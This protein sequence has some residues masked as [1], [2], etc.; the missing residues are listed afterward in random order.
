MAAKSTNAILRALTAAVVLLAGGLAAYRSQAAAIVGQQTTAEIQRP[1]SVPRSLDQMKAEYRRP[2]TIPFPPTNPHTLEKAVLGKKLYFDTRLS[3]GNLLS[4][5]TCHNPAFGWGDAQPKAI[6]HGMNVL[7]RRSPSIVNAAWSQALMWDGREATLETQALGPIAAA[8][9]MNMPLAVL[10]ERLAGIGE[11]KPLFTAAFGTNAVTAQNVAKALATFERTVVSAS[12]P[13]DSWIA[14]DEKA[15]SE[16]A[17]RGFAL[18][19]TKAGCAQCHSGWNFTD[20]SF[21]DIG[22]ESPD[23]GRGKLVPDT[24]KLQHAFKTPGLRDIARRAPFAHDGS[25]PTLEAVVDHY[26]RGGIERPS[27]SDII[28]PLGLTTQEKADL[29]AF[30][31]TLTGR[32]EPISIPL[33]PR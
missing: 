12:A 9:E 17:K 31:Q 27:R 22:L 23:L 25:L 11:Y 15:I 26:D 16:D 28:K 30:L 18:F 4:C 2:E 13:F 5:A 19:N 14:G 7:A 1:A 10:T 32:A 24:L 3:S 29:V 20:D 6:G 21:H 33:L 8:A